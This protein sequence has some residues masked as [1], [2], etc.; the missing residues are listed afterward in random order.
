MFSLRCFRGGVLSEVYRGPLVVAV[1]HEAAFLVQLR[2][3]EID[4]LDPP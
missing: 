3:R 4:P 1:V 2:Q